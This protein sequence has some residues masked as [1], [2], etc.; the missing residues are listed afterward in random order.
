MIASILVQPVGEQFVGLVVGLAAAIDDTNKMADAVPWLRIH[1][2]E[3]PRIEK[4]DSVHLSD[5]RGTGLFQE[6][7]DA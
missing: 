7:D 3:V 6:V 5:S 4:N 1:I 2:G